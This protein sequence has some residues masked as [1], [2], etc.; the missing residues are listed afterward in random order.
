MAGRQKKTGATMGSA[1]NSTTIFAQV[2]RPFDAGRFGSSLSA[3]TIEMT[4]L[5]GV[6]NAAAALALEASSTS[7]AVE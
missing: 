2:R 5:S 6:S 3:T 4:R 1:R 7:F